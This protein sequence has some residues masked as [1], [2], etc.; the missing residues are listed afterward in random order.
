MNRFEQKYVFKPQRDYGGL[1]IFFGMF[2]GLISVFSIKAL[3]SKDIFACC[4]N[5]GFVI[6]LSVLLILV[7]VGVI[8]EK[9]VVCREYLQI[10]GEKY[11]WNQIRRVRFA[12]VDVEGDNTFMILI[13][14]NHSVS[15]EDRPCYKDAETILPMEQENVLE[16]E[17]H[18]Y[19]QQQAKI[20]S[21]I[22]YY[23]TVETTVKV[24]EDIEYYRR[25]NDE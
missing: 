6:F 22:S 9:L 10:H 13:E 21:A 11:Y 12:H 25:K 3:E 15:E 20:S 24:E 16:R 17:I 18:D 4:I 8:T 23:K 2:L 19:R 14:F 7:F 5:A 1:F